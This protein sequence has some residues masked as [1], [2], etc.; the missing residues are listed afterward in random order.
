VPAM[1]RTSAAQLRW[2][3]AQLLQLRCPAALTALT[4]HAMLRSAATLTA[5]SAAGCEHR[6]LRVLTAAMLSTSAARRC[7]CWSQMLSN[8]A[9]PCWPL[10][11][12]LGGLFDR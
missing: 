5:A 6:L 8:V 3:Y 1:P 7:W 9:R 11:A 4:P 2:R 10:H 12:V